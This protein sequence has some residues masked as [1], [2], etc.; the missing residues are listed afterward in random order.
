MYP[1]GLVEAASM[2]SHTSMPRS[3]ANMASSFTSA[4]FTW[5]NVFSSSLV[6][7]ASRVPETATVESTRSP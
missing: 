1:N 5:R 3:L 6:S 7:S 2:A 4:M